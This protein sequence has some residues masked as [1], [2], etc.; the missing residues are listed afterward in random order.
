MRA[1]TIKRIAIVLAVM[2]CVLIGNGM[3]AKFAG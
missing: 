2:G 1:E 3:Y